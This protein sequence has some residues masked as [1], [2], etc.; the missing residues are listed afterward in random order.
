MG[1]WWSRVHCAC[2]FGGGEAAWRAAFAA[3]A[4]AAACLAAGECDAD[5]VWGAVPRRL[6]GEEEELWAQLRRVARELHMLNQLHDLEHQ[7][8][9]SRGGAE[10]RR[11]PAYAGADRRAAGQWAHDTDPRFA[12]DPRLHAPPAHHRHD[13]AATGRSSRSDPLQTSIRSDTLRANANPL[14]TPG[15]SSTASARRQSSSAGWL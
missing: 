13:G 12:N 11:R 3:A 2:A 1:C 10:A 6:C 15:G 8:D 9:P 14:L 4:S 7:G 5:E